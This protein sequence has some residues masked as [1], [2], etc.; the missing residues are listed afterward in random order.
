MCKN[1]LEW[2]LSKEREFIET[3][4]NTRFNF[5]IVFFG[6]MFFAGITTEDPRISFAI[7]LIGFILSWM[8]TSTIF[9]AQNKL[10]KIIDR[11]YTFYKNHPITQIDKITKGESKRNL[12]GYCIPLTCLIINFIACIVSLF[13]FIQ[14]I[15]VY[16]K[17][18]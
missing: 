7:Y 14:Y 5:F 2:D 18:I 16:Y 10:N 11:L 8:L 9:R 1:N 4:L 3:L 6:A 15:I 17:L 12:I 13:L